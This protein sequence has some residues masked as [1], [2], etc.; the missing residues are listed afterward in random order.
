MRGIGAARRIPVAGS[1][2]RRAVARLPRHLPRPALDSLR[3]PSGPSRRAVDSAETSDPHEGGGIREYLKHLASVS[4]LATCARSAQ[5][6]HQ[7]KK[8]LQTATIPLSALRRRP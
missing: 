5:E 1:N 4:S 7:L 8:K 2:F 3:R 6:R